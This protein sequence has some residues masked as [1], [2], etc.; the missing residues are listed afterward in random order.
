MHLLGDVAAVPPPPPLVVDDDPVVRVYDD[1]SV[2][3][4]NPE[5]DTVWHVERVPERAD[6]TSPPVEPPR[7]MVAVRPRSREH[8]R[9]AGGR[10]RARSDPDDPHDDLTPP[11][12]GS[13]SDPH[14]KA[15]N[16]RGIGAS[17]TP[18]RPVPKWRTTTSG[19]RRCGR[20]KGG[21]M[22]DRLLAA[23]WAALDALGVGDVRLATDILLAAAEDGTINPAVRQR[24]AGGWPGERRWWA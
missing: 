20:S 9:R 4:L 5:D 10:A 21:V 6:L 19:R 17:L 8:R 18:E 12:G 11:S 15:G 7:V 2:D 24:P 22:N 1:G 13:L 23:I 14:P 3:V 16:G